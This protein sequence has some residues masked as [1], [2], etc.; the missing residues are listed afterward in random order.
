[1]ILGDNTYYVSSNTNDDCPQPCHP[2]SHYITNTATYFTSNATFI[3]MEGEH[4]LDSKG[5]VQVVINNAGNLT[6][7]GERGHSN[8]D[9]TIRCSSNTRGLIFK[10][11]MIINIYD[12][13]ITGCGQDGI[14][15]LLLTN[16]AS[17]YIHHIMLY[18]NM[19]N[20]THFGGI[21]YIRYFTNTTIITDSTITNNT[22]S[23]S[24][25]GGGLCIDGNG[26]DINVT[27]STFTNNTVGQGGGLRIFVDVYGTDITVTN[28]T[29]TNNTV[30][31]DGGGLYILGTGSSTV[32]NVTITNSAF[33]NNT[34][35]EYGGG[36]Y[37]QMYGNGNY[38]TV[39]VTNIAFTNN[40]VDGYGGGLYIH[41]YDI[42]N[43]TITNS[44]FTNNTVGEYGGGLYM[45]IH[46]FSY[47]TGT[48]ITVANS[49]FTNNTV[50]GYGGGLYIGSG[51]LTVTNSAFTS[52]TT[53]TNSAFTSNTVG[54]HG[55][56][57]Y[58]DGDG[59]E[60]TLNITNSAFTNNTVGGYG[61][62]LY[63][64]SMKTN[65][66]M[67]MYIITSIFADNNGSGIL[68]HSHVT[69]VL[70]EG[71]SVVAN[72][73][74]PTDG[75]GIYLGEDCHLTTS[76]GGHVSFINNTAQR[77][78]GAIYSHDYSLLN[79]HAM[80]FWK[81]GTRYYFNSASHNQCTIYTT[82][83]NNSAAIAGDQL[84]GGAFLYHGFVWEDITTFNYDCSIK[85]A[86]SVPF[87][88][89]Y[90]I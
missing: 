10:N 56:G 35:G 6:L 61:G 14:P 21:L 3:F 31:R 23:T 75:G 76:Y 2:L 11:S 36:L 62:G 46:M 55:G 41:A 48:D 45:Y 66:Y 40:T 51:I 84:Y 37:I 34:V 33:T 58:I 74:S 27:N 89:S 59:T 29:F 81:Y 86:P 47:G 42:H 85:N 30:V 43:V 32:C 71:H 90:I 88:L 28:S 83:I 52:N 67:Y 72:N 53:V 87:T 24:G 18:N 79:L 54:G 78:G 38:I 49:A 20:G 60:I 5:L 9:I 39:N 50:D 19:Y 25:G 4:L 73:S 15:P 8:T 22:I 1:M 16:I 80:S 12:V 68:A 63:I 13:S 65:K 77:Y 70:T 69:V 64:N 26:T 7:R 82:F 57:L 44:A 17:L